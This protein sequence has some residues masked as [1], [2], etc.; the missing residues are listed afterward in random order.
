VKTTSV[1]VR[2]ARG[3][4]QLIQGVVEVE[5]IPADGVKFAMHQDGTYPIRL[6]V[7][8]VRARL[9]A[10]VVPIAGKVGTEA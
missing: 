10:Q 3:K 8:P 5:L 7:E 2:T 1:L 6:R 4:V 9:K